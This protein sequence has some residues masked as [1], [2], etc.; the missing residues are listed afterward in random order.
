MAS[1]SG[2]LPRV[3]MAFSVRERRFASMVLE[4]VMNWT[5]TEVAVERC[6]LQVAAALPARDAVW[7][8]ADEVPVEKGL[9]EERLLGVAIL[10]LQEVAR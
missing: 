4:S 3:T 7:T 2:A 1:K 5:R 6:Q 9:V 8:D 10:R